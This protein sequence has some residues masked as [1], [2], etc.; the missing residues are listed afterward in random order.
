MIRRRENRRKPQV[1]RMDPSNRMSAKEAFGGLPPIRE[2]CEEIHGDGTSKEPFR[3]PA[4][5]IQSRCDRLRS[6]L[7]RAKMG[8]MAVVQRTDL[9]YLTGTAQTGLL[10]F[11]AR[12]EPVL[13]VRRFYPRAREECPL[14][15]VLPV[16]SWRDIPSLLEKRGYRPPEV[17]GMEWDVLPVRQYRFFRDLLPAARYED[18]SPLLMAVRMQKSDWE[19]AQMHR[20]AEISEQVFEFIH[21]SIRPGVTEIA[22]TGEYESFARSI[23]H[24]AGLRVRDC[25]TEVY[26]WHLL[27]G[28]A[29]GECGLLDSPASGVGTS[30]AFPCGASQRPLAEREPI[31]I[32]VGTVHNGYHMDET[33]MFAIEELPREA[34]AASRASMEIHD[35]LIDAVRPGVTAGSVFDTAVRMAE[36]MGWGEAFLGPPGHKVRFVGHGIGL[37]LVEPPLLAKGRQETITAGMTL[38]LEPK[39]VAAGRFSAGIESVV[40]VTASGAR[41]ISRVPVDVF[42][43]KM[44]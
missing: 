37:E 28:A 41:L 31:L 32:D 35:A 12:G 13:F 17:M 14:A 10:W 40:E 5:E 44:K 39:L 29:G 19:I 27:A 11:P 15:E 34:L 24:A 4:A 23:G 20:T 38:A 33:R 26:N 21:R 3:V 22:F 25:Q 9:F 6:A 30:A 43:K 36:R 8:A 7:R 16:R 2:S 18:A 42:V 1:T